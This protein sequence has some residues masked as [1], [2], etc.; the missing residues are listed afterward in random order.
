MN[1]TC[2]WSWSQESCN[3]ICGLICYF[4]IKHYESNACCIKIFQK[5]KI[6]IRSE[7]RKLMAISLCDSHTDL[8]P[9]RAWWRHVCIWPY[10]NLNHTCN[11]RVFLIKSL[12]FLLI[13][14]INWNA[15]YLALHV[16]FPTLMHMLTI[17]SM[18]TI[19]TI[20]F[21]YFFIFLL[22][23]VVLMIELVN[24]T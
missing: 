23:L 12:H 16:T 22:V 20:L 15:I 7:I 9:E 11:L 14:S 18:S 17:Y 3:I 19:T 5:L 4:E 6:L 21:I 10:I 24:I 8:A 13:R 2:A 1:C